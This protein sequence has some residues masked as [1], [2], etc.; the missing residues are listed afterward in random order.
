MLTVPSAMQV[1][2]ASAPPRPG[3]RPRR[4]RPEVRS[5]VNRALTLKALRPSFARTPP[6]PRDGDA[7]RLWVA[8]GVPPSWALAAP[9][10]AIILIL[11]RQAQPTPEPAEDRPRGR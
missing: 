5:L 6:A 11:L 3:H 8:A 10:L 1:R 9:F 2:G 7:G 4:L